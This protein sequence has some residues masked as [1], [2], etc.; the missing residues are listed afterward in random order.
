[1]GAWG[2][3]LFQSDHDYDL[4]SDMD[5]EAG[6]P[7]LEEDAK[8]IAEAEHAIKKACARETGY[9]DGDDISLSI[10][11]DHC[12]TEGTVKLVRDHLDSGVLAEMVAKMEATDFTDGME[13]YKGYSRIGYKYV[14]LGAC[15]MTLGCTLPPTFKQSLAEKYTTV[16]L[17]RVALVQMKKALVGPDAFNSGAPYHFVSLNL[18]SEDDKLYPGS[19]MLNV[20]APGNPF[21]TPAM[22]AGMQE[23]MAKIKRETGFGMGGTGKPPPKE[24]GTEV[25]GGCGAEECGDGG[26]LVKCAKCKK[27][28]Y[29]GRECQKKHWKAHKTVCEAKMEGGEK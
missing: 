2:L 10:F 20:Q 21:Q 6:I 9:D 8:K 7:K 13:D 27:Q 11:A 29:C 14:L 15:A 28:K 16:G 24:F 3:G 22:M 23:T 5:G 17:M 19:M 25:C 12:S 1:M 4:I 18:E 26:A